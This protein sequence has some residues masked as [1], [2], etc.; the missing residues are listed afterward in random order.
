MPD[1][2]GLALLIAKKKGSSSEEEDNKASDEEED[3]GEKDCQLCLYSPV[4]AICQDGCSRI[5]Q[6]G[7]CR[8]F[9][10]ITAGFEAFG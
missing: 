8:L 7:D 1:M 10:V 6:H 4:A 3:K 5:G 2:P 9:L